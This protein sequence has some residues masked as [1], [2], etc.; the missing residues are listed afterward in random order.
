MSNKITLDK[1]NLPAHVHTVNIK[2]N[3]FVI[4]SKGPLLT[5]NNDTNSLHRHW[6]RRH[7]CR[8]DGS[9]CGVRGMGN[10]DKWGKDKYYSSGKGINGGYYKEDFEAMHRHELDLGTLYV[11]INGSLLTEQETKTPTA[12][13]IEPKYQY[14]VFIMKVR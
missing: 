10:W 14:I 3:T 4:K 9:G 7:E 12:F 11:D 6:M 5:K 1:D 13:S 8:R 2:D